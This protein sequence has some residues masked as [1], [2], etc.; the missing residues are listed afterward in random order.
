MTNRSLRILAVCAALVAPALTSNQPARA[1]AAQQADADAAALA[2]S[3]ELFQKANKLYDEGKY[4][5]AEELYLQAWRLKKSYDLAGNLGN[6]EADMNKPRAAAEYLSFAVREFPAGGRPALRDA[7]LKRLGEVQKLVG[8]LH[9]AVNK[10][11]AEVQLDGQPIGLSPLPHELYVEPGT[12]SVEARLEGYP[13]VTAT[14]TVLKGKTE[15]VSLSFVQP[16]GP[17]KTVIGVGAGIAGAGVIAGAILLGVGASKG[18]TVSDLQSKLKQ[19][20]GCASATTSG[21]CADLRSAGSSKATLSNAGLWTL[22]GG[23]VV[24]I[25]TLIY[26]LAGGGSRAP[27][28][29]LFVVPV[30]TAEGGGLVAEGAF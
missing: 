21:D 29:G 9:F 22:V 20:G 30:V 8:T 7:L 14:I 1:Q 11:G 28:S 19:S 25:G 13:P 2:R 23:G 4:P 10:P 16:A 26:G 12:H 24:G 3:R 6:L 15:Q 18:G 27:K 5:Q 17:N